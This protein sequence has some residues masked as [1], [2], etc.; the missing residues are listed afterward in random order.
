MEF[1]NYLQSVQGLKSIRTK[2]IDCGVEDFSIKEE[3]GSSLI[4]AL[5]NRFSY[6]KLT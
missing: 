1:D 4:R 3:E 6:C 2:N 5:S